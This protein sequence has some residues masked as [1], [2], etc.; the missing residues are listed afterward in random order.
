M[1]GDEAGGSNRVGRGKLVSL[2]GGESWG[3]VVES[4]LGRFEDRSR[5]RGARAD[6][7]LPP[8]PPAVEEVDASVGAGCGL[9]FTFG[10]GLAVGCDD[11]SSVKCSQVTVEEHLFP[12]G[13][14]PRQTGSNQLLRGPSSP[15]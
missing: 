10:F 6:R 2:A 7:L 13:T 12:Y 8:D 5:P 1:G 11:W 4:V 3:D 9:G 14:H 15:G